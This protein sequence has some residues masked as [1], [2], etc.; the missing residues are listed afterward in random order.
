[1]VYD[2]E[3]VCDEPHSNM[4]LE[5]HVIIFESNYYRTHPGRSIFSL[6]LFIYLHFRKFD[7]CKL[8]KKKIDQVENELKRLTKLGSYQHVQRVYAVQM[9][10]VR[11]SQAP[12]LV[13]LTEKRPSLTL[14][15]VLQDCDGL[16][17]DRIKVGRVICPLHT[18][19]NSH[20]RPICLR[21]VQH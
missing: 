15:D 19:I 18:V 2:A 6:N 10:G 7:A 20:R 1:M 17:E 14:K 11:S 12:R 8:G 3:P 16:R 13:I 5:L 21:F 9:T 4:N